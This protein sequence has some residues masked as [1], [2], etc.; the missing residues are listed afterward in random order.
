MN[1]GESYG[2][3]LTHVSI[4]LTRYVF[5]SD[6]SNSK[7][8]AH[9]KRGIFHVKCYLTLNSLRCYEN[10][11]FSSSSNLVSVFIIMVIE[12]TNRKW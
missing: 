9:S 5:Q 7:K 11:P 10:F 4:D 3:V 12:L 6:I 8:L 2:P 1:I